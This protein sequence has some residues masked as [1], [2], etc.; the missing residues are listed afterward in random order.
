MLGKF[1]EYAPHFKG[2]STPEAAIADVIK[3]INN[4]TLEKDG[5]AYVSHYGNKQWL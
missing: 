5:G 2:P 1:V 3:V 4:A